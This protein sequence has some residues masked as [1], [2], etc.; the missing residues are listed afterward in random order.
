MTDHVITGTHHG[1]VLCFDS[2]GKY[3]M[4]CRDAESTFHYLAIVQDQADTLNHRSLYLLHQIHD[5]IVARP[6][7]LQNKRGVARKEKRR[8][9]NKGC[10][11][12]K[13]RAW[14]CLPT[15]KQ[16]ALGTCLFFLLSLFIAHSH[17]GLSPLFRARRDA[18]KTGRYIILLQSDISDYEF[19]KTLEKALSLSQDK[20]PYVVVRYVEKAFTLDLN[21][22]SLYQVMI[23]K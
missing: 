15:C 16:M 6:L 18:D 12:K 20:R 23:K 11:S 2:R 19:N 14:F 3:E 8:G 1:L 7:P 17:C 10:G 5:C 9:P 22:Y 4:E 13:Y 21:A